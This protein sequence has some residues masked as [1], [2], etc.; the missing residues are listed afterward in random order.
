MD[1]HCHILIGVD[2]GAQSLSEELE[3]NSY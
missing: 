2:D 3:E 1:L